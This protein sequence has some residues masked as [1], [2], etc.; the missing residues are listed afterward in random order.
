MKTKIHY[1]LTVSCLKPA[2]P[3]FSVFLEKKEEEEG[4]T[5]YVAKFEVTIGCLGNV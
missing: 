5:L 4:Q 2:A 3:S 1:F